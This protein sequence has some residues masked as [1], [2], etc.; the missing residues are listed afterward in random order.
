MA[1]ADV[2]VKWDTSAR[3]SWRQE[4]V[5]RFR[6][7]PT[8]YRLGQLYQTLSLLPQAVRELRQPRRSIPVGLDRYTN[9]RRPLCQPGGLDSAVDAYAKQVDV[10]PNHA[11]SHGEIYFLRAGR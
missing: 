11:D 1:L 6:T 5:R 10:S 4:M 8:H 2:L 7:G 3:R 9:D